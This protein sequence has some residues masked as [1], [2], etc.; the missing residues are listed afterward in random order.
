METPESIVTSY[1]TSMR[2]KELGVPQDA[3]FVWV[4]YYVVE[5]NYD[6]TT[7][8]KQYEANEIFKNNKMCRALTTDEVLSLFEKHHAFISI[9]DANAFDLSP[10]PCEFLGVKLIEHIKSKKMEA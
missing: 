7:G 9:E 4:V 10:R 2:L 8:Y 5:P 1:E 3:L 6:S